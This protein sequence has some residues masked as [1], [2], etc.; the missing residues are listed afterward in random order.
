LR[1]RVEDGWPGIL[2]A[3]IASRPVRLVIVLVGRR[4][5]HG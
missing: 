2:D 3:W 1:E 4:L 5:L